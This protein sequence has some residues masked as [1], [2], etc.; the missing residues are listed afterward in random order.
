MHAPYLIRAIQSKAN[1]KS[2]VPNLLD[3]GMLFSGLNKQ[4]QN[5]LRQA[6]H[7]HGNAFSTSVHRYLLSG[8][9]L[10]TVTRAAIL[11]LNSLPK[12]LECSNHKGLLE[13]VQH[14]LTLALTGAIYGPKNPYND[15]IIE[16]SWKYVD[17]PGSKQF[18]P[19]INDETETLFLES[20]TCY[21][22][23]S[24]S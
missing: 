16:A 10:E 19:V 2:L 6:F 15:P 12:R 7:A 22:V 5:T 20:S 8:P 4:S 1:T 3:F 13:L 14:E 24:R 23:H 18:E 21:T 9:T 11:R 17:K